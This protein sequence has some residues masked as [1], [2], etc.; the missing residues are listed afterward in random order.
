MPQKM[1]VL[2]ALVESLMGAALLA[3]PGY[4]GFYLLQAPPDNG[5]R[6][7]GRIGGAA[8]LA[9]GIACWGASRDP[10]SPA[11]TSVLWGVTL[12]NIAAGVLLLIFVGTGRAEGVAA[13]VAAAVHV[14]LG[15]ALAVS[16]RKR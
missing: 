13:L 7:I 3:L 15:L 4:L 9:L 16:L 11:R 1:L 8:L 12:Y 10:G 14:A 2:A 5:G 6:M